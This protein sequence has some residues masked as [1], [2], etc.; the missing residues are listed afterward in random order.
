MS[1]ALLTDELAIELL[2]WTRRRPDVSVVKPEG[3][4]A[5]RLRV[6]DRKVSPALFEFLTERL[7][8][9]ALMIGSQGCGFDMF[10]VGGLIVE[11]LGHLCARQQRQW[12]RDAPES[13][14]AGFPL[15]ADLK[16]L[17]SLIRKHLQRND[18]E[19]TSDSPTL[20]V[21]PHAGSAVPPPALDS[22]AK[23]QVKP[24]VW[25]P[26]RGFTKW[27]LSRSADLDPVLSRIPERQGERRSLLKSLQRQAERHLPV[28]TRAHV[29]KLRA[30]EADFPNFG[31]VICVIR[32][33]PV[34]DSAACRSSIPRE[35]GPRFRR[36]PVQ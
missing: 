25:V 24:V 19:D 15:A 20:K 4:D 5:V 9:D 8:R 35:V 23:D 10:K 36:M 18:E 22:A 28:T 27:T 34:H 17:E 1:H 6:L 13:E 12:E 14:A 30:L 26:K 11:A 3:G 29:E 32:A 2:Q 31:E 33:K 7:G 21:R 16:G